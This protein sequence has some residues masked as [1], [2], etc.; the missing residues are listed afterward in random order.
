MEATKKLYLHQKL[1]TKYV[2]Q[3]KDD[4]LLQLMITMHG[5]KAIDKFLK[6]TS[7]RPIFNKMMIENKALCESIL[8]VWDNQVSAEDEKDIPREPWP[9]QTEAIPF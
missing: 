1:G 7:S 3:T 2:K 8:E 4:A 9:T 5:A 6:L